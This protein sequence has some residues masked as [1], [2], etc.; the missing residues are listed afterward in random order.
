[1]LDYISL[2]YFAVLL[3]EVIQSDQGLHWIIF[4]VLGRGVA[5]GT[6]FSFSQTALEPAGSEKWCVFFSV[7]HGVRR[8][9]MG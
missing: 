5:H 1:V 7:Q 9:S 8:L 4:L 2:F 3:G 6:F